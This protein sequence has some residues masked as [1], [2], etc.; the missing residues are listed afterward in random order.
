MI[1]FDI[2]TLGA[3]WYVGNLHKW[4]CAPRGAAF[5]VR[6]PNAPEIHPT[7]ISHNYGL[8]FAAEF[9]QLGTRNACAWLAA[10]EAIAFHERLG[11]ASLRARNHALAIDAG[12]MIARTFGTE[13][14]APDASYGAMVT[15]RIPTSRPATRE[16][17]RAVRAQIWQQHRVEVPV[18]A[19]GGSLWLRIS[20]AAYNEIADY[21]GLADTVMTVVSATA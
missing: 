19:L 21:E 17:G 2:E 1:E 18:M 12:A 9:A 8:G 4:M 11:G 15:V 5:I 10:P 16:G 3:T 20:A 7:T 13:T 6:A 14:G